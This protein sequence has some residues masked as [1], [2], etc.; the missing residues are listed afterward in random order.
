MI[1]AF[2][3]VAGLCLVTCKKWEQVQQRILG[4]AFAGHRH[5]HM[6]QYSDIYTRVRDCF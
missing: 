2:R 4:T 3:H 5:S 1:L 6:V